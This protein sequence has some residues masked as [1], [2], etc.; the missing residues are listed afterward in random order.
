MPSTASPAPGVGPAERPDAAVPVT[1]MPTGLAAVA[2]AAARAG[3]EALAPFLD[4]ADLQVRAKT[5]PGDLVTAADQAS[6][7]AILAVL[8]AHRPDDAVLGEESGHHPG[9]S[10]LTWLVDPVDGTANFVH[11]RRDFAVSVG[12]ERDGHPLAGVVYRPADGDWAAAE[13][14]V[15]WSRTGTLGLRGTD[16][17]GDALVGV[18]FPHGPRSQERTLELLDRLLPGVRDV[19]RIGSA[20][21]ELL[22]V[23]AGALDAYVGVDLHP[24]DVAG[25]RALVRAAGGVCEQIR[26]FGGTEL[27][28]AANPV[29]AAELQ[30][31]LASDV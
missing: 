2:L 7:D 10:G 26:G 27:S 19:R 6:E 15:S 31:L 22:Y 20:A 14:A 24:W 3:V 12:L 1:D 4:G 28:V 9:T 13:G 8:R 5:S 21:C 23:A 25:G 18:G 30:E 11:G 29:L 16:R 17:L